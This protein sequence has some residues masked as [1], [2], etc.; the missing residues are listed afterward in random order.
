MSMISRLVWPSSVNNGVGDPQIHALGE[1]EGGKGEKG[2][3]MGLKQNSSN[4]LRRKVNLLNKIL[5]CNIAQYNT[6]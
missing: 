4:N 2:R 1:W 3:E 6:I 5:E